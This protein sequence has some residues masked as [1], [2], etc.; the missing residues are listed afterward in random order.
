MIKRVFLFLQEVKKEL[1]ERTT[2]PSRDE[3]LNSTSFVVFSLILVSLF[4]FGV[5]YLSN[6][7][8][9]LV[10]VTKVDFFRRILDWLMHPIFG[11]PWR[12]FIFLVLVGFVF[13]LIGKIR[14]R[15]S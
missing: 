10:V 4:L 12:F 2:W 8:V 5:D 6:L 13:Y 7:G 3:V 9:Q 1:F 14:K 11:L 15:M